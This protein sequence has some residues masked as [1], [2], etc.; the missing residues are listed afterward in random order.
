MLC[1]NALPLGSQSEHESL[2]FFYLNAF[3]ESKTYQVFAYR[4]DGI[5]A[6]PLP[7]V[8]PKSIGASIQH[9]AW[10]SAVRVGNEILLF[11]SAFESGSWKRLYLLKSKDGLNFG[12]A[13][14]AFEA[15]KEEPFGIGPAHVTYD[16]RAQEPFIL[17]YQKRGPQGPGS[18]INLARS[19]DGKIWKRYGEILHA[20]GPDEAAGISI[21]WACQR[22]DG[23]WILFYQRFPT[24]YAG[25]AAFVRK[26][27]LL[28][29]VEYRTTML[30]GDGVAIGVIRAEAG[31]KKMLVDRPGAIRLGIPHLVIG[32]N[33]ANQEVVVPVAYDGELVVFD[34]TFT[35]DWLDALLVSMARQ[36]V[37]PSY[38]EENSDGSWSGFVTLFGPWPRVTAEYTTRVT[39]ES[40]LGPWRFVGDGLAF[41]LVDPEGIYSTENPAR[42][43][44]G[45]S[46]SSHKIKLFNM[47]AK[48]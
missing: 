39:G 12:F 45:C 37:D 15:S 14:I 3:G 1:S 46:C 17:F 9:V 20:K 6:S 23:E 43:S 16:A 33:G 36:K 8:T 21:S 47:T 40:L 7:V 2:D 41:A 18:S 30:T 10:P 42:I 11:V 13:E 25:S 28:G 29:T 27:D 24:V 31:Q 4:P 48:E 38:F 5:P 34:R 35:R 26:P 22:M 44:N 19:R 32:M